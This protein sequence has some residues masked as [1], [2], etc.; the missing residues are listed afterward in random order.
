MKRWRIS[1]TSQYEWRCNLLI[2]NNMAVEDYNFEVYN[3]V[4]IVLI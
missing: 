1:I 3:F 4:R 2:I